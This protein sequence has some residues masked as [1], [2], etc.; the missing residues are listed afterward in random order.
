M[1]DNK[2]L[3][4]ILS[5]LDQIED[6]LDDIISLLLK[7]VNGKP[8]SS[9][10]SII[11]IKGA[12]TMLTVHVNDKPGT[13]KYQEFDGPNGTGNKVPPT[14]VVAYVSSDPTVAT[15]DPSTGQLA[16][17]AAGSTTISASDGG[18]LPASD[19]LTVTAAAAVS[20]T[21]TLSPGV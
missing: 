16:Y 18:N 20:S 10:I 13:A 7:K 19:V 17:L 1:F 6:Q 5:R 8:V 3:T 21:M 14:G 15:V 9:T 12:L 2:K 11:T 4:D